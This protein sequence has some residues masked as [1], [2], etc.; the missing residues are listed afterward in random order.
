MERKYY[1]VK[2]IRS[3]TTLQ[4]LYISTYTAIIQAL[5]TNIY[6]SPRLPVVRCR[7]FITLYQITIYN[8][9]ALSLPL[10]VAF[11]VVSEIELYIIVPG[12]IVGLWTAYR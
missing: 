8:P 10:L 4:G 12:L 6:N 1:T 9:C 3:I 7:G 2:N 11:S 5:K